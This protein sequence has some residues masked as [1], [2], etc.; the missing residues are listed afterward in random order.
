ME[1]RELRTEE[2]LMLKRAAEPGGAMVADLDA[3]VVARMLRRGLVYL[4]I[5]VAPWEHFSIPPLEGFVSNKNAEQV[6]AVPL[7]GVGSTA[8]A[9]LLVS[10][11]GRQLVADSS[12]L[13][14]Q[15]VA[16][17]SALFA[18]ART[19]QQVVC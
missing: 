15:L 4:D 18:P 3:E 8:H 19:G 17:S 13:V 1:F 10:A 14:F 7:L 12:A 11:D 9:C 2:L 16:G 6:G 5:P